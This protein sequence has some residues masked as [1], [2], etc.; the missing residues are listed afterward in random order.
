MLLIAIFACPKCGRMDHTAAQCLEYGRNGREP[1]KFSLYCLKCGEVGHQHGR[2]FEQ[3]LRESRQR[4]AQEVREVD[5]VRQHSRRCVRMEQRVDQFRSSALSATPAHRLTCSLRLSS[6]HRTWRFV[7]CHLLSL[8]CREGRLLDPG[9]T[10]RPE[11]VA[12]TLS[13]V[14]SPADPPAPA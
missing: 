12:A 4:G 5:A 3:E 14:T 1:P 7:S 2:G 8:W 6:P 10:M 13:H 9:T 11:R